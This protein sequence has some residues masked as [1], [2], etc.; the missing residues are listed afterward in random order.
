MT[1]IST[2]RAVQ[3]L[4]EQCACDC[5]QATMKKPVRVQVTCNACGASLIEKELKAN[6]G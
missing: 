1:L 3:V 4:L 2:T 6:E 5:G